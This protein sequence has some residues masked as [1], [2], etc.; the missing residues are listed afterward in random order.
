M[1][2]MGMPRASTGQLWRM[3]WTLHLESLWTETVPFE[4]F[5]FGGLSTVVR[6]HILELANGTIFFLTSNTDLQLEINR[7]YRFH[8]GNSGKTRSTQRWQGTLS[9]K[10]R[11]GTAPGSQEPEERG[12]T[13]HKQ[14]LQSGSQFSV[15]ETAEAPPSKSQPVFFSCVASISQ[16]KLHKSS[17]LWGPKSSFSFFSEFHNYIPHW[18]FL[19][20]LRFLGLSFPLH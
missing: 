6:T 5:P 4:S 18:P 1:W 11:K 16:G 20:I 7:S 14:P 13:L 2:V 9:P 15:K 3:R 10:L 8:P 17:A 12:L 19:N